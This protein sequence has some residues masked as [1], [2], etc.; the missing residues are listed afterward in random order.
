MS[1]QKVREV[2]IIGTGSY[3][4]TRVLT[5]SDLERMVDT[6]DEWIRTRTGISERHIADESQAASDLAI[7]AAKPALD[8]AGL[9]PEQIQ[10]V[11][12]TSATHDHQFPATANIVQDRLGI[13][14]TSGAFDAQAGCSGFVYGLANAYGLIAS[15]IYDNILLVSV[16][17]LSRITD[18]R[19]RSTCVLLGDG[20]GAV[21]L[22]ASDKMGIYPHFDL[23]SEGSGGKHLI[24]PA[25]GSRQPATAETVAQGLHYLRM[26]GGE[27]FK[28]AVRAMVESSER[29]MARC[30]LT[31]VDIDLVI[32]HQ[33]NARI[34]E[35]AAKR[36]GFSWDKFIL[37]L[38]RIGNTSDASIPI[39]LDYAV[40]HGVLTKDMTVLL[41]AF[42]AGLSWGSCVLRWII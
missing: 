16:S 15:S 28:F 17:V 32:P 13:P 27:V 1:D 9:T 25:G 21:V 19:D 38:D 36:W 39:A 40:R 41:T 10:A 34:I 30:G 22:R 42:G 24:L 33:A 5:N 31:P 3:L 7:E 37:I 12:V 26:N 35:A 14:T 18:W 20:A 11:I 8:M 29:I 23:G 2:A 4:P 6:S